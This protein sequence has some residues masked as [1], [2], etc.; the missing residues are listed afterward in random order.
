MCCCLQI[1][2]RRAIGEKARVQIIY[3]PSDSSSLLNPQQC[4]SKDLGSVHRSHQL[5]STTMDS[6]CKGHPANL[7]SECISERRH[8]SSDLTDLVATSSTPYSS[9][10]NRAHEVGKSGE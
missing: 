9:N 7:H 10:G 5:Q 3:L 6:E 2:H 4:G 1:S 8:T